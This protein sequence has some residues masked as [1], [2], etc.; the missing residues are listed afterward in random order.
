MM[1][2]EDRSPD[3]SVAISSAIQNVIR[4]Q[5]ELSIRPIVTGEYERTMFCN[6][7]FEHLQGMEISNDLRIP[8]DFRRGLKNIEALKE[9]GAK[10]FGGAIATS[11]IKHVESPYLP[12]WETMKQD[13]PPDQWKDCKMSF[14]SPTWQHVHL[15]KNTAYTS[16]AYTTDK[17][18]FDDLTAAYHQEFQTL[19]D[20]GLRSIQ[21]D[22]PI[23]TYF[24]LDDFREELRR[25]GIDPDELLSMYI[26][27]HNQAIAGLPQDMYTSIHLCRGNMPKN[28]PAHTSFNASGSYERIAEALFTRLQHNTLCLEFDDARSGNFEPLRHVRKDTNVVLGLISTKSPELENLESMKGRIKEAAEIIARGQGRKPEEVLQDT[29]AVSTQCGFATSHTGR[30]VE[31]EENMWEKLMLVRELAKATWADTV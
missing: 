7:F 16:A 1:F 29:L 5:L 25:D 24:I 11:K 28:M 15:V 26:D 20:A 9:L 27:V 22:D 21:V 19:Y 2:T 30:G 8:G 31:S 3:A 10:T 13:I 12:V 23:L 4:K 18:Y 17:G 14:I 6:G